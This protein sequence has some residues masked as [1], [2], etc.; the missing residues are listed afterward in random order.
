MSEKAIVGATN[1]LSKIGEKNSFIL[2]SKEKSFIY[3]GTVSLNDLLSFRE[4]LDQLIEYRR[5]RM[6]QLGKSATDRTNF[7]NEP[8]GSIFALAGIQSVATL[9][10]DILSKLNMEAERS[11]S[12]EEAVD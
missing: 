5:K 3:S 8:A 11:V 6:A 9:L 4:G 2:I 10:N 7:V 12:S 1:Q